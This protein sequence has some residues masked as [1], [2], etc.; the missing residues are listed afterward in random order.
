MF[1]D[2][3]DVGGRRAIAN[4]ERTPL[5]SPV[6]SCPGQSGVHMIAVWPGICA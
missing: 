1:P 4:A 5:V 6:G 3:T 2:F